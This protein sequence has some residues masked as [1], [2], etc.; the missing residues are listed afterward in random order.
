MSLQ[1]QMELLYQQRKEQA[2]K[3]RTIII[4]GVALSAKEISKYSNVNAI[5][6]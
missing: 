5:V 3:P 6:S 4:K 2:K 1:Q